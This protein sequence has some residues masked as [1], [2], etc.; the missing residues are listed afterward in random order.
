MLILRAGRILSKFRRFVDALQALRLD[1]IVNAAAGKHGEVR[2]V[3]PQIASAIGVL[4]R[5]SELLRQLGEALHIGCILQELRELFLEL[6]VAWNKIED[7]L[8]CSESGT[9]ARESR[10]FG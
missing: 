6:V 1:D 7:A 10:R 2:F 3:V 5:E 8:V 4:D 9:R